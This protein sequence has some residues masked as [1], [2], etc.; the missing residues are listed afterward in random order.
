MAARQFFGKTVEVIAC[1]TF[2]EVIKIG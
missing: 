1:D 2:R